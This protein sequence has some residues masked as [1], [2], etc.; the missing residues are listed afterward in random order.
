MIK[1][2]RNNKLFELCIC[3]LQYM[4]AYALPISEKPL[5]FNLFQHYEFFWAA[6]FEFELKFVLLPTNRDW[7]WPDFRQLPIFEFEFWLANWK[8]CWRRFFSVMSICWRLAVKCRTPRI[9]PNASSLLD[10][11]RQGFGHRD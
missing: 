3:N 4:S 9:L 6:D 1:F 11:H 5:K 7:R 2:A 10:L 8:F